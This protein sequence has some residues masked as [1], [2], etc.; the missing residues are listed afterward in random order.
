MKTTTQA[1]VVT[2]GELLYNA[3]LLQAQLY[4]PLEILTLVAMFYFVMLTIASFSV[5]IIETRLD[6]ARL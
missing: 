5:R 4:R 2:Y 3:L 1:S 6:A